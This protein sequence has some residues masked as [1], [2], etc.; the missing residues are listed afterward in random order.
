MYI[1]VTGTGLRHNEEGQALQRTGGK[2]KLRLYSK[3][4]ISGFR[5]KAELEG[6][7]EREILHERKNRENP[8]FWGSLIDFKLSK[9]SPITVMLPRERIVDL[10]HS[11]CAAKLSE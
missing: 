6:G 2:E 4:D 10:G 8:F 1:A 9:L 5:Q 11:S 3:L 7:Q